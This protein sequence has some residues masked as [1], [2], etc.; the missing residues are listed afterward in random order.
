MKLRYDPSWTAKTV[1][2]VSMIPVVCLLCNA[3][4]PGIP[5]KFYEYH[6]IASTSQTPTNASTPLIGMG[7][8]PSINANG[9]VAFVGQFATGEGL[10]LGDASASPSRLISPG[11]VQSTR[12]FGR[13]VQI[14]D[15]GLV[16]ANNRVTTSPILYFEDLWVGTALDSRT[17]V[18]TGGPGYPFDSVFNQASVNN[19]GYAAF[20]ALKGT[21][22]KLVSVSPSLVTHS[23]T[24]PPNSLPR[25]MTADNGEI[26]IRYGNQ[27][28]SP[29]YVYIQDLSSIE[30][31]ASSAHFSATGNQPG[32]S[33]DGRVV[34]FYGILN[35]TGAAVLHLTPG[36]GIFAAIDE[37][38]SAPRRIV[39]ILG[40]QVEDLSG[41]GNKDGV[42]DGPWSTPPLLV[43]ETCKP[44]AELGYDAAGKAIYFGLNGFSPNAD[45]RIGVIN[46]DFGASGIDADTFVISF[47]GTPSSASRD[48]PCTEDGLCSTPLPPKTP[49]LFSGQ[50]GLWTVRV[51]VEHVP[52]NGGS[53]QLTYHS[54]GV[55]P[56]AQIGDHIGDLLTGHTLTGIGVFDPIAAAAKT[57]LG[58]VRTQRR[59]DHRMAFWASGSA[60]EQLIIRGSHLDSDQDGLLDHWELSG[61]DM[62]QDGIVDLNLKEMGADPLHRDLFIEIDW[63]TNQGNV[64]F[65]PAPGVIQG[66]ATGPGPLAKMFAAAPPLTG[67]MYGVRSDNTTIEDIPRGITLHIDGGSGT[68]ATKVAELSYNMN[69]GSLQGGDLIGLAGAKTAL[70]DVVYLGLTTFAVQGIQ[71]RS[72]GDIKKNF[73]GTGDKNARELAF[74]GSSLF[75]VGRGVRSSLPAMR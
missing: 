17:R 40:R 54:Y 9:T 24:L 33:D 15:S 34:V 48:N 37:G 2:I 7:N 31:V 18:A 3:A 25:P 16:M 35:D 75:H 74:H 29:I 12:F 59:G 22:T 8:N 63:L 44:A 26:V 1:S 45:S 67:P 39:R 38:G 57:D 69:F 70:V 55:I 42:C 61:I 51:D 56:V 30:V 64:T 6:I 41:S 71:T 14:N 52:I 20:G 58:A 68:D 72:F 36:P 5:G 19:L 32:I 23:I 10:V 60:G 21:D 11:S 4:T 43:A 66:V 13:A 62:D 28:N 49:L 65:R 50:L 46:V 47:M 27:M 73:F 53:A